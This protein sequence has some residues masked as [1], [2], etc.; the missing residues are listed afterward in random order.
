MAFLF[1]VRVY[2]A[3]SIVASMKD[4]RGQ[5]DVERSGGV[6][7]GRD[8]LILYD[9]DVVVTGKESRATIV[10]RDGSIIRL[11]SNTRFLIERSIEAEKGSRRFLHDF[12]L[13][14]GAFWGKFTKE[15]Q[16]TTIR[17]PTATAGI[18]GTIISMRQHES[19]LDVSLTSGNLTIHNDV[20]TIDLKPGQIVKEITSN[21]PFANKL[22]DLPFKLI[23]TA[24]TAEIRIAESG[25]PIEVYFTLQMVKKS[26]NSNAYRE[27]P[28]YISQQ[29]DNIRFEQQI[30]LNRRGYSRIKA[31]VQPFQEGGNHRET[32]EITALMDGEEFIDVD[33]GQTRV[34]FVQT[35][36]NAKTLK[37]DVK[38]NKIE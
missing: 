14:L 25:N 21:A 17:T 31:T 20:E 26:A 38:S 4:I 2:A 11:F 18:K 19:Q 23:I 29:H 24:E 10:F 1:D 34:T 6:L 22:E 35:G 9:Q 36:R 33:A 5:I 7:A 27:G 8:G 30:R 32:I 12:M 3:T 13:K 37:I 15:Y 28:V 16:Q